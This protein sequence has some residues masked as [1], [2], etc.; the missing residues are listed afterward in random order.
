MNTSKKI[1]KKKTIT[2]REFD[3]RFDEG[4][5]IS[6]YLDFKKATIVKRVNVDFP[7]WMI[8]RLDREAEKLNVSRQAIIKIWIQ[9]RIE[10]AR[11]A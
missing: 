6:A 2:A 8:D 9:D 5:D 4:E 10:H 3:R 1:R 7:S 11:A